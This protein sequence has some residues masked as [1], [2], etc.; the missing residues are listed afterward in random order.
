MNFEKI[1][2]D[3]DIKHAIAVSFAFGI[4]LFCEYFFNTEHSYWVAFTVGMMITPPLQGLIVQKTGDRIIGTCAGILF[5]FF[6]FNIFIQAD[7]R[8]TYLMFPIFGVMLYNTFVSG[9][10]IV[11][12]M[13]VTVAVPTSH[14][15][16][17]G[18]AFEYNLDT[19]LGERFFYTVL[20]IIIC[21]LCEFFIYRKSSSSTKKYKKNT[22]LYFAGIA[23]LVNMCSQTFAGKVQLDNEIRQKCRE[24]GVNLS[25]IEALYMAVKFEFDEVKDKH[26]LSFLS[27]RMNLLTKLSQRLHAIILEEKIDESVINSDSLMKIAETTVQNFHNDIRLLV[28]EKFGIAIDRA[29]VLGK[30]TPDQKLSPTSLFLNTLLE[31]NEVF[32]AMFDDFRNKEYLINN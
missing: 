20:G 11:S 6:F 27:N 32:L 17:S 24:L 1:I 29:G 4:A 2:A 31:V 16:C 10:Y 26:F 8:W 25:S 7:Y 12:V 30:L 19:A 5:C 23:D 21:L 14:I 13:F 18:N 9:N 22:K 15:L 3:T 28:D